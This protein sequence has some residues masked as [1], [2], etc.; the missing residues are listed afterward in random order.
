MELSERIND[1]IGRI[2]EGPVIELDELNKEVVQLE[3]SL[4]ETAKER[5]LL[6]T[7]AMLLENKSSYYY[8]VGI[9]N[10]LGLSRVMV[11]W[12][13]PDEHRDLIAGEE[14]RD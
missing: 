7:Y 10:A 12:C 5:D 3:S 13:I 8:G 2:I 4:T 1:A 6:K 9:R 14:Q 11:E